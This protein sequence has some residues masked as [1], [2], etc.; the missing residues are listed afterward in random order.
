MKTEL[1]PTLEMTVNEVIRRIPASV[2]L[3]SRYGIDAC[4]GG[5]LTV[6]EAARRHGVDPDELLDQV[7]KAAA[8]ESGRA[9]R[10]VPGTAR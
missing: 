9:A 4:C 7:R 2:A 10:R 1:E 3:F 8:Q 5:S 6:E